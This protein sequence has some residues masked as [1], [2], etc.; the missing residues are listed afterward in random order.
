MILP[1][2]P[3][4]QAESVADRVRERVKEISLG[5]PDPPELSISIG[6]ADF[7]YCGR[8]RDSLIAAADS[9]LM[10]AKRSGRDKVAHFSNVTPLA[11]DGSALEGLSYRLEGADLVT[12]EAL[13]A[14]VDARD[15]FDRRHS[16]GVVET[17]ECVVGALGLN[18]GEADMVKAA[19]RIYDVG[20]L[21][22]PVEVL[23]RTT[24]LDDVEREA[25]RSHPEVGRSLIESTMKLAH[26]LPV[27][28]SH[29]EC[30]DG[31]GYPLGL[32]GEE[33][34]LPARVIAICDA[35]QAMISD[36]PYRSAMSQDDAVAELR[37]GAGTQFDP[38]LVERFVTAILE[39]GAAAE[40]DRGSGE[41]NLPADQ[42][43]RAPSE[44]RTATHGQGRAGPS[45]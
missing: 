38:S 45:D 30:W 26:L 7:P 42:A 9:A 27:V 20:K 29:H 2:T 10:F 15:E 21:V 22:I 19:A 34:A 31:S 37:R 1:E 28:G 32:K 11:W 25:I 3:A 6:V 16:E 23:N 40:P 17:V 41:A 5:V 12:L 18:T 14:A 13:A 39:G 36:R 4:K 8:E 35:Y 24:A 33:I 44:T 43:N